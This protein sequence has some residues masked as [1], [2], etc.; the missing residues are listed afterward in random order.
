MARSTSP[1]RKVSGKRLRPPSPN[2]RKIIPLQP[3]TQ[4]GNF[5]KLFALLSIDQDVRSSLPADAVTSSAV[6]G[7]ESPVSDRLGSRHLDDLAA[8]SPH[9]LA[10]VHHQPTEA[11]TDI[12]ITN[13]TFS[14]N[15]TDVDM[16]KINHKGSKTCWVDGKSLDWT[17]RSSD[18]ATSPASS[19]S[20]SLSSSPASVPETFQQFRRSNR[21]HSTT[22]PGNWRTRSSSSPATSDDEHSPRSSFS[23]RRGD[24]TPFT[25]PDDQDL[26][27]P[28]TTP[29]SSL[30]NHVSMQPRLGAALGKLAMLHASS[31]GPHLSHDAFSQVI[32][33]KVDL[34]G[35]R[36]HASISDEQYNRLVELGIAKPRNQEDLTAAAHAPFPGALPCSDE[37]AQRVLQ[38]FHDHDTQLRGQFA[39]GL[40][41]IHVFIDW[42]NISISLWDTL[43][44][45]RGM[46]PHGRFSAPISFDRLV[47]VLER[48][49]S[50]AARELA[51]S[52]KVDGYVGQYFD[53]MKTRGYN[54][55]IL[56]R[57]QRVPEGGQFSSDY[58]SSSSDSSRRLSPAKMA[59]QCVD[60]ILQLKMSDSLIQGMKKSSRGI[61]VL[62]T[63][64]A[65]E[66]EF[67]KGF[68]SKVQDALE[69][70]W[71]VELYAFRDHT[72]AAW[73]NKDFQAQWKGKFSLHYL[74]E[75]AGRL[76]DKA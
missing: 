48:R 35:P 10:L 51:G 53:D 43:R 1:V 70:G 76:I 58:S 41:D 69:L 6:P 47:H 46:R 75:Y 49:R 33:P 65:N 12:D 63:G 16:G 14:N 44:R 56:S 30:D 59:E 50:A 34:W 7:P 32:L 72:S 29:P 18:D 54:T 67:S 71:I 21:S 36:E 25:D 11:P 55:S 8:S 20:D 39:D 42:S 28:S 45:Q 22:T 74:D 73:S 5:T 57:V 40:P 4:L 60:E 17:R 24:I 23:A 68:L 37:F 66:A 62:A 38:D 61:M 27:T 64:D 52:R 15:F 13:S 19:P 3:P 9:Q 2:R 26:H 31:H